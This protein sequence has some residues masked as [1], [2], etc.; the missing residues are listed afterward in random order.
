[1]FVF[2]TF[3]TCVFKGLLYTATFYTDACLVLVNIMPKMPFL[4]QQENKPLHKDGHQSR[5]CE[6]AELAEG[7]CL[8][9]K[10]GK[11]KS[12]RGELCIL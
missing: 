7:E 3:S 11:L 1:V 5:V 2:V 8:G 12:G 9:Q 10:R 4:R 6:F